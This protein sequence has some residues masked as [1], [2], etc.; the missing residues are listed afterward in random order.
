[1]NWA[2]DD[3]EVRKPRGRI[4]RGTGTVLIV[5]ALAAVAVKLAAGAKGWTLG[6]IWF[7]AHPSS[8]GLA[9]SA[10]QRYV[11]PALWDPVIQSILVYGTP[12]GLAFLGGVLFLTGWVRA[13]LT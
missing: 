1:M 7:A 5:L 11:H 13:R 4:L 10:V 9:Q 12:P 6:A 8:L 2:S 3:D